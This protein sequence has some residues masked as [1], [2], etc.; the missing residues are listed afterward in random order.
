MQISL[1]VDKYKVGYLVGA[2]GRGD[3][4]L[5]NWIGSFFF[6]SDSKVAP[7]DI[8]GAVVAWSFVGSPSLKWDVR[9]KKNCVSV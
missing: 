9:E 1:K 4:P 3:P 6:L 8:L 5:F 2:N 7:I